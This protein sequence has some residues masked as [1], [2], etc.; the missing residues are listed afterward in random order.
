MAGPGGV[1]GLGGGPWR[2]QRNRWAAARAAGRSGG[3]LAQVRGP[4]SRVKSS[5]L[6]C[7]DQDLAALHNRENLGVVSA[8]GARPLKP[9]CSSQSCLTTLK[10]WRHFGASEQFGAE[11]MRACLCQDLAAAYN[12]GDPDGVS[13]AGGRLVELLDDLEELLSSNRCGTCRVVCSR[14]RIESGGLHLWGAPNI[15]APTQR[16]HVG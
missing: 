3:T 14:P 11:N 5:F 8:I 4:S 10:P 16:V 12:R 1:V 15:T 6:V 2:G 9:Q 7:I 13:T